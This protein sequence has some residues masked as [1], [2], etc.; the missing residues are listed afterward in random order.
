MEFFLLESRQLNIGEDTE[1]IG[2]TPEL[3]AALG[4]WLT[5]IE[6]RLEY[7]RFHQRIRRWLLTRL[8]SSRSFSL[9]IVISF[10]NFLISTLTRTMQPPRPQHH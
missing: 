9:I 3:L 7:I 1:L 5:T 2:K 8:L 4:L 6:G 10:S